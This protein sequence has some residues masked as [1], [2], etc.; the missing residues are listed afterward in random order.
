MIEMTVI[1]YLQQRLNVPVYA[2]IPVEMPETFVVFE[3]TGNARNNRIDNATIAVQSYAPT[4]L[5]A[6][7]LNEAVKAALDD[8]ANTENVFRCKLNSDYNYT[9]TTLKRYR[10]QAVYDITF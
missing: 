3:K 4:L 1:Q 2:E 10:Y 9:D 8:M 5:G 7:T 6:A